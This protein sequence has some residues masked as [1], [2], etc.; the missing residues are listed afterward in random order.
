[1][2]EWYLINPQPTFN[3][4]YEAEEWDDYVLDGMD[5]ILDETQL[6][7]D[8]LLCNGVFD[9]ENF[10]TEIEAKA[11]IQSET[12]D[13]YTQG[14]IRQILVR[15]GENLAQYKYV[16]YKDAIWLMMIEP[17]D[18]LMY[19]KSVLH[20][21][22]YVLKWQDSDANVH[23]CPAYIANNS[24]YNTGVE[25]NNIV[26]IGYNQVTAFVSENDETVI[27][28]RDKRMFVDYNREAP[29]PYIITRPDTV[30]YSYGTSRVMSIV[31][32][33]DQ[34][35]PDKDRIDLMLCDFIEPKQD[36]KDI[37]IT[38]LGQPQTRIGG[39]AKTYKV[40]ADHTIVSWEIVAT[41]EVKDNI[42]LTINGNTC[43]VKCAN[44]PVLVGNS[45]KLI[46][47]D[48]IGLVGEIIIDIIGG[49]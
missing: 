3:S 49:V 8:V 26:Q 37:E 12:P 27:L 34:Y 28:Q 25:G 15:M 39:S 1:M 36:T 11:V 38:Y 5:E 48:D 4:G 7:K 14:W 46:C 32:T 24:Q 30:T 33:E 43:K 29:L 18:N 6:G 17:T 44:K 2:Q 23:F 45:F 40:G 20:R 21:C 19:E 42:T 35:N 41:Q 13:A 10:E 47:T 22:N 16:K 9:G 31:F